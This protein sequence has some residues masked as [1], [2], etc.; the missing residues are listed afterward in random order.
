MSRLKK[1]IAAAKPTPIIAMQGEVTIT[2]ADAGNPEGPKRFDVVA[3]TGGAMRVRGYDAPVVVDLAGM[4]FSKSIIANLDHSASQRV[5]HVTEKSKDNGQ[6]KLGGFASAST[7]SRDEVINSAAGG[8]VW[9]ASIEAEP[10]KL[11]E[12]PAGKSVDVNGQSFDGPIYLARKSVL[13]GFAFVSHGADDNTQVSIAAS[14]ASS[15]EKSMDAEFKKWIEA[16]GFDPE[17]LSEDQVAGLQANYAGKAKPKLSPKK[18]SDVL[19]EARA[20]EERCEKIASITAQAIADNPNRGD[21]FI[22]RL[23]VLSE[24]AIEAKWDSDRYE[25]ELLRATRPQAH[26]VFRSPRDGSHAIN[27]KVIEAAIC[28]GGGLK[29]LED[30][31]DDQTLQTAHDKFRNGIGIKQLYRIA[32][33]SRGYFS[34]SDDVTLELQRAAFGQLGNG[35]PPIHA[36]FSTIDLPGTLGATAN[37]FLLEG[38]GGGEMVWR[39]IS[40]VKSVRNFQQQ[41]S[42]KLSGNMKYEKVNGAGE[43]KHGKVSEDTYTVKADTYGKMFAITRTDII[44]DD[45]GALTAVPREL[46]YGAND[47][48]NEVF[49]TEFLDNGS[50]FASGNNNLA[51]GAWSVTALAAAEAIFMAQTKPNGT[52][53]G[54]LP[55]ILLVPPGTKRVAMAAMLSPNVVGTT[56]PTP[57]VNT[58]SGNYAVECSAYMSNSAYTG[59]STIKWYLLANRPGFS[60]IATAFLN[61]REAPIVESA[62]ADF[63][64]L[65]VQMRAY[66]DFGVKKQEYRAGVQGSGA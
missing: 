60:T 53:L 23:Q 57:S 26:P 9:Q 47:A 4:Q 10:V 54:L 56:G 37:K 36:D 55:T 33:R 61:G 34:D 29:S 49:W 46:G 40:D 30:Q 63:S 2:A 62:D 17:S 12:I 21:E 51:T 31:F 58:F 48:M 24:Q 50:F 22:N 44:N 1:I 52:P 5:G 35:R 8:F 32:A 11:V 65:G 45:L 3:Y 42:Y 20:D 18:L 6:L 19:A 38:W 66:H 13:K 28:M 41:T 27:S 14:A 39:N 64:V 7:P 16:M 43:L 59:Y 25:L 15:K